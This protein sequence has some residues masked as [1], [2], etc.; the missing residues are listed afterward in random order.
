M[1]FGFSVQK[2]L[3]QFASSQTASGCFVLKGSYLRGRNV[4]SRQNA[5][6]VQLSQVLDRMGEAS[7]KV[8]PSEQT[9]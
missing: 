8:S 5:A 9:Y 4:D 6:V 7:A 2:L 1:E 3:G